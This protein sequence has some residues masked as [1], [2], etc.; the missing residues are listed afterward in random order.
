MREME[1]K[2]MKKWRHF[3]NHFEEN[4]IMILLPVMCVLVFIATV[5]RYTGI[6]STPWSEELPR[7]IMIWMVLL[8]ASACSR[9]NA[10]FSVRAFADRVRGKAGTALYL[11]C[12]I[13]VIGFFLFIAYYGYQILVVQYQMGQTSTVLNIP[14]YLVYFSIPLGCLLIVVREVQNMIEHFRTDKKDE[15]KEGTE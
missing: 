2:T 5:C 3:L 1:G 6:A 12:K 7:Y 4:A 10:H 15:E 11:F 9:H 8:G 13:Y 14:M